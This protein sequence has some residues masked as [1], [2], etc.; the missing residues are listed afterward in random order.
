MTIQLELDPETEARLKA[1]AGR[2]GVAPEQYAGD[3]LRENL[4]NYAT[5]TGRLKPGDVDKITKVMTAGSEHLPILP[6]EVNDWASYY[7]DRW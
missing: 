6:P 5:G 1:Q 2:H 7:E 3:F 4:P